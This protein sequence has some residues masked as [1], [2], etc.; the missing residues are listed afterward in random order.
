[1]LSVK[2]IFIARAAYFVTMLPSIL[3]STKK[4]RKQR[5]ERR[6]SPA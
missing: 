6:Y 3:K 5:C 4:E 2:S 1:L